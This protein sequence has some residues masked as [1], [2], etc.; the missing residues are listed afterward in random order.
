VCGLVGIVAKTNNGFYSNQ[1]D[2]FEEMLYADALRG[3][4]STGVFGVSHKNQ[5][6]VLKQAVDPGLLFRTKGWKDWKSDVDRKQTILIGH[7]RKATVG[8][9]VSKTAHP[10][11]EGNITFVHNGF[12]Q[13]HKQLDDTALVDSQAAARY[14]NT[15]KD[16]VEAMKGIF[17]AYAMIWYNHEKKKLYLTRNTERPLFVCE[18]NDFLFI[19]SEDDMLKWLLNRNHQHTN[20]P[21]IV[22]PNTLIEISLHPYRWEEKSLVN[23]K[24]LIPSKHVMGDEFEVE[25]ANDHPLPELERIKRASAEAW[26]EEDKRKE[27]AGLGQ[28][29]KVKELFKL[30]PQGSIMLFQPNGF[31]EIKEKN[32][33]TKIQVNGEA[34]VPG[35]PPYPALWVLEKK[36]DKEIYINNEVPLIATIA[37]I[38]RKNDAIT[39]AL[40]NVK[41]GT[42]ILKD[43]I[44]NK[45]SYLEWQLLCENMPCSLCKSTLNSFVRNASPLMLKHLMYLG[46]PIVN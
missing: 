38:H 45:V 8:E 6:D 28:A 19:A 15:K 32:V 1:A 23:E 18:S 44:G 35:K 4:D 11:V 12:I 22:K 5:V 17:G 25:G 13:N 33:T 46:R 42:E 27:A 7:N 2:L 36:D 39:F 43:H 16:E 30:Y 9:V 14:I 21:R 41:K 24:P 40:H 20:L 26:K 31:S 10:F 29:T 34:W 37:A 3:M